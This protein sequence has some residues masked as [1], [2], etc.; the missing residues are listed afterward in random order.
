M[1]RTGYVS[2]NATVIP[3]IEGGPWLVLDNDLIGGQSGGFIVN[4]KGEVVSIVQRT[5]QG[6]GLGVTVEVIRTKM[7]RYFETEPKE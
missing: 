2:D 5:G 1:F 7:G 4:G 3:G 6:M